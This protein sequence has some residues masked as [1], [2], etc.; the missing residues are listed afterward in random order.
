MKNS[1]SKCNLFGLT[2]QKENKNEIDS[3]L[4]I[5]KVKPNFFQRLN[6]QFQKGILKFVKL[7]LILSFLVLVVGVLELGIIL[8][9]W[10]LQI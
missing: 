1:R 6:P 8:I 10:L 4:H 7:S 9:K 3:Q 2:S 5:T